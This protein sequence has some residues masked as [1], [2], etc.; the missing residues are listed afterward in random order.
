M[1]KT[2][3]T[4]DRA[5]VAA[6]LKTLAQGPPVGPGRVALLFETPAPGVHVARARVEAVPGKGFAGDHAR[7]SFYRGGLVPG[8]EV[9]AVTIEVLRI[10]DVD[11]VLVGDNLITEGF[12]LAA[13]EPGDRIRVG[14]VV[15]ERSD[16]PHQACT[17]FRDRTTPEAFAAISRGRYRGALFCVRWGGTIRVG[18]PITPLG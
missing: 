16:R 2:G 3:N 14:D 9:T 18:D 13:L 17:V 11:P 12:D 4:Y 1:K 8:R 6:W 5:R 15:L 7:K 10:L